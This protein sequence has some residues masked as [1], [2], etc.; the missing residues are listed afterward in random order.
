MSEYTDTIFAI[1]ANI[2]VWG[3]DFGFAIPPRYRQYKIQALL[4]SEL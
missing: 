1:T 2:G 3:S 4:V